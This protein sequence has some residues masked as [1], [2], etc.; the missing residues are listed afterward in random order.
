ML[1]ESLNV[2]QAVASN[3]TKNWTLIAEALTRLHKNTITRTAKQCRERW[4]NHLDPKVGWTVFYFS[5][6]GLLSGR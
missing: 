5:F 1:L 3:G 6:V 2:R 4:H